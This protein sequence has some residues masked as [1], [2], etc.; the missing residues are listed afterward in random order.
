MLLSIF[1][2]L[3]FVGWAAAF[4]ASTMAPEGFEDQSGFHYGS[5]AHATATDEWFAAPA[6]SEAV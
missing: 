5:P 4:V 3:A 1:V 6:V 2:G